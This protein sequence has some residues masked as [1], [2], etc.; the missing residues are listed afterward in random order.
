[1]AKLT[2]LTTLAKTSVGSADYFLVTNSTSGQSNKLTVASL[3]PSL[4]T[5]GTSSEDIWISVTNKNQLNFKGIK[6][7]DTGL[8]TVATTSNNIVLTALEA[9]IDL[10]LCDNTTS[11]FSNGVDFTGTVTG[12]C[13]VTSGGT[14][15]STIGKG[16]MFYASANDVVAATA[17]MSTHGQLLIGNATS[18]I[19]TVAT[20]TAGS[21]VT[22]TNAAGA[23]T[24]AAS[25]TTLAAILDMA[26]YNIDLGTGWI[27]ADGSTDQGIKVTAAKAFV[28][29]TANHHTTDTLNLSG[30]GIALGNDTAASIKINDTTSTTAGRNLTIQGGGS[31]NAT[32]GDLHLKAGDAGSGNNNGG[33][34]KIYGG[35]DYG[36]G[37]A[38]D[39]EIHAYNGDGSSVQSLSVVGGVAAPDVTVNAGNLV[40]TAADK[41]IMHTN[42]GTVTQATN[43]ATGVTINATSGVITLAAVAL[44]A[45]TNAEFVVT[46]STVQTTSVILVTMQDEN[47]VNNKQLACAI[48]TVADGAFTISIVN[49]HSATS[50][51]ATAS[52][53]HFLVIN[54]N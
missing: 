33:D 25:L 7:G 35:N 1:M 9:G 28:G 3:F 26:N 21:N 50:T 11:D 44:A 17:A 38:G 12:E 32:A 13:G 48:H 39:V 5:T 20:L 46:N 51:S 52:K 43:H 19:P 42:S 16:A 49:P 24:I 22:I 23:I 53:I 27:S 30:G 14:G 6:S 15:L 41:G 2:D 36:A 10:S 40:I 29:V 8:L 4:V 54:P 47:T 37:T 18:G 45:T 34:L 31:D